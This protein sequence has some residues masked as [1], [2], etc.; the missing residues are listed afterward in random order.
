[1]CKNKVGIHF[2]EGVPKWLGMACCI[3]L[4]PEARG[5]RVC[6]K[7]RAFILLALRWR[8][9]TWCVF[10]SWHLQCTLMQRQDGKSSRMDMIALL[11]HSVAGV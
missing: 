5:V 2:K 8:V 10:R 1:M 7:G 4:Q 3:T 6:G 11:R 9:H